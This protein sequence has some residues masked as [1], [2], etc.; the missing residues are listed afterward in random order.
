[1]SF[2]NFKDAEKIVQEAI[3]RGEKMPSDDE[4]LKTA[5]ETAM[6]M[7]VNLYKLNGVAT[8]A[9]LP[10]EVV[11][12]LA[13]ESIKTA[14]LAVMAEMS[15]VVLRSS[16]EFGLDAA[17]RA[18]CAMAALEFSKASQRLD[19]MYEVFGIYEDKEKSSD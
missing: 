6:T 8:R 1:M 18:V 9:G 11:A 12:D 17:A 15:A 3:D 16:R 13:R 10:E 2:K 19:S 7:L 14:R 4:I 5:S